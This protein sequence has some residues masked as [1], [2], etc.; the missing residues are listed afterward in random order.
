[1]TPPPV[2]LRMEKRQRGTPSLVAAS[3]THSPPSL[4]S[5]SF[6][7]CAVIH[8]FPLLPEEMSPTQAQLCSGIGSISSPPPKDPPTRYLLSFISSLSTVG[9]LLSAF[10]YLQYL[11]SLKNHP[12]P[13]NLQLPGPPFSSSS[14]FLTHLM[15]PVSSPALGSVASGARMIQ[16]IP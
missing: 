1:M 12:Y 2:P 10:K 4:Q 6:V 11:Q 9:F 13:F 16:P 7:A 8:C 14:Q 15:C 5:F 3:P